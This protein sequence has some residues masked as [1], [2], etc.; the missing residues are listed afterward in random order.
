MPLHEWLKR[1]QLQTPAA[2]LYDTYRPLGLLAG[3][4]LQAFAPLLPVPDDRLRRLGRQLS[5]PEEQER[6]SSDLFGQE[7]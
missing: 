4:L 7:P 1:H 5:D 3:E 2:I 6:L